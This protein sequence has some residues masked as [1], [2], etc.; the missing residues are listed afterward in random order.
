MLALGDVRVFS[1]LSLQQLAE[2]EDKVIIRTY[3]KNTYLFNEGTDADVFCVILAGRVKIFVADEEGK[4]M[5]LAEHQQ[6]EYFGEMSLF[7]NVS[8]STSAVSMEKTTLGIMTKCEFLHLVKQHPAL[9]LILANDLV[10]RVQLLTSTVKSLALLDVY[11]RV[12]HLLRELSQRVDGQQVIGRRLTQQEIADRIGASRE[13]VA[14][15]L[16][17]LRAGGYLRM[18]PGYMVIS[19]R[20]PA[21]Y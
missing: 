11:G 20:L 12:T 21:A 14:R 13:R 6:G 8:R 18:G 3:A 7:D 5:I 15:I 19:D 10:H 4:E 2:L 17:D 9:A 16:K 1:S